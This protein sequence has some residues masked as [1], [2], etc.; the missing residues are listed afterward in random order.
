[1]C[2]DVINLI[3]R[4]DYSMDIKQAELK[5]RLQ[6]ALNMSEKKP[7]DLVKDLNIP[8]S[9]ISQ[10]LSG[11]SKNMPSERLYSICKYLNVSEAWMMGYDVPMERF[12][13]QKNNDILADIIVRLRSDSDFLSVVKTLDSLD[14]EKLSSVKQMLLAFMK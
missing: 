10:Y 11:T 4:S 5:D 7:V 8:K 1:M 6:E 3:E 12:I 9:A 14:T 2:Y 13:M